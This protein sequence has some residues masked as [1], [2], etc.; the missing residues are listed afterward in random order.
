[1]CVEGCCA[2]D[3]T[4]ILLCMKKELSVDMCGKF[5]LQYCVLVSLFHAVQAN[6]R[7]RVALPLPLLHP[8]VLGPLSD[9]VSQAT[10]FTAEHHANHLRVYALG[11][12][13]WLTCQQVAA[14]VSCGATLPIA[15]PECAESELKT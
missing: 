3:D 9:V 2:D 13:S 11:L 15:V 7:L 12:A 4:N 5:D 8:T 6:Q 14:S 10:K 1:M